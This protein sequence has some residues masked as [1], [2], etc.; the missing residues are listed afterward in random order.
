MSGP[1]HEAPV[2]RG[3][4]S[5]ARTCAQS[6]VS[7]AG[8]PAQQELSLGRQPQGRICRLCRFRLSPWPLG[9]D[10]PKVD[11]RR[12][13]PIGLSG[14][15]LEATRLHSAGR[16]DEGEDGEDDVL[17]ERGPSLNKVGESGVN[18]SHPLTIS[19]NG[20]LPCRCTPRNVRLQIFAAY[21]FA[22]FGL[23]LQFPSLA[24]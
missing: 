16:V 10:H 13:E 6:R 22:T 20:A 24:T 21:S 19:P 7:R 5:A 12:S 11:R 23:L 18:Q 15:G 14:R 8:C 1:D 4:T 9:P 17:G 3:P 2:R